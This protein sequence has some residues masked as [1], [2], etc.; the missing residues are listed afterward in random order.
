VKKTNATRL[1]QR[2]LEAVLDLTAHREGREVI[3]AS[4]RDIGG[5]LT[6]AKRGDSH[7]W[8]LARVAHV[9]RNDILKVDNSLNGNFP[10]NARIQFLTHHSS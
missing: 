3:E 10:Q 1:K 4:R 2:F 5:I 6:E 7:A 9:V 8:R